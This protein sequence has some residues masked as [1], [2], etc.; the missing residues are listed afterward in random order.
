MNKKILFSP[1]S[2]T[3]PISES[4]L[5]DG[6]LLHIARHYK[7][8]IIYLYMSK[9]MLEKQKQDDRYRYCLKKL[10][11]R[12]K[13]NF[14]VKVI[15]RKELEKVQLFDAIYKDFDN[16]L[17]NI[18]SVTDKT[19]ELLLNISSGTPA[20]KSAL[21]VLATMMDISCQCIQVDTPTGQMNEHKHSKKYDVEKYWELNI[22]NGFKPEDKNYNR[23]HAEKLI[24]LKRIKYEEIIK[25]YINM[26]NYHAALLLAKEMDEED[27]VHYIGKLKLA[28]AR[29]QLEFKTVDGLLK[30][31][32]PLVYSPVRDNEEERRIYE[33]MLTLQA[34][35]D[36]EE[37]AEFLRGLSPIFVELFKEILIKQTSCNINEVFRYDDKMLKWNLKKV[38]NFDEVQAIL[39]KSGDKK[40]VTTGQLFKLIKSFVEDGII[41]DCVKKLRSVES[42]VRN[43]AAH[44]MIPISDTWI[45]KRTGYTSKEI[46]DLIKKAFLYTSYNI[47]EEYWDSYNEMNEDI[48]NSI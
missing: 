11:E 14:E 30:G 15:E 17:K 37:Y 41:V 12:L 10:S 29:Q 28:D 8:D 5:Y 23:T 42:T 20:M 1:V 44:N 43:M 47:K 38:Q 36:R 33:Y 45:K 25:K 35:V 39:S 31:H 46:L 34:R 2:G 26:Y 6:P 16:E 13:H 21:L 24:S 22:D 9:E 19:D 48:L 4:N 7:P 40:W 27:T 18:Q 32:N 3:D